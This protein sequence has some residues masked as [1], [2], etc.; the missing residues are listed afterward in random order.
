MIRVIGEAETPPD[1]LS[2]PPGGPEIR[3]IAV[4]EGPLDENPAQALPLTYREAMRPA[5]DRL[6]SKPLLAFLP[7]AIAPVIDGAG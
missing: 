7:V 4:I 6:G 3:G 1:H 5:C 2:D